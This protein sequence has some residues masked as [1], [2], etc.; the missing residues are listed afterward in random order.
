MCGA[1]LGVYTF[2]WE[3]DADPDRPLPKSNAER[4]C[5]D[6]ESLETWAWSR[7]VDLRPTLLRETGVAEVIHM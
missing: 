4:R 5:V 2:R 7:K 1:N 3:N 6:W